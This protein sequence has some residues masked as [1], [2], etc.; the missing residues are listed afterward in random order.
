VTAALQG[1]SGSG[2]A[3]E[4]REFPETLEG[5]RRAFIRGLEVRGYARATRASYGAAIGMFYRFI[6]A[7]GIQAI[8]EVDRE[9]VRQY[10]L[11]LGNRGRP[12]MER[13]PW[14]GPECFRGSGDP[15]ERRWTGR[16]RAATLHTKLLP[17]RRFFEHLEKTDAI[18]F[19]PC[20]G[21]ELPK[22][23]EKLPKRILTRE[24]VR[25]VFAAVKTQ[26]PKGIRDRAILEV[27]YSTGIRREEMVKLG[28]DDVDYRQGFLRVNQGKFC[29]DRVAPLGRKACLCVKEY[30]Q[31]VRSQ[32]SRADRQQRAL[33]LN[34]NAP[35]RPVTQG[36]VAEMIGAYGRAAGLDHSIS[37]HVWRHTCATH[38]MLNGSNIVHVQ[39]LLGHQSLETTQVYTRAT[40]RDVVKAWRRGHP[41]AKAGRAPASA[42]A[43]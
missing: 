23:G 32:W 35:H 29:R 16:Y 26:T 41:R 13:R 19:N 37:P 21:M 20:V 11:W 33:W 40:I 39:K 27:F 9:T 7:R 17:L 22:L 1:F 18:F 36:M 8:P 28:I 14:D 10:Q 34:S 38:M 30:L 2:D 25:R 43:E 24:E 6:V 3:N 15:G 42:A 12:S 31:K 4:H 5:H